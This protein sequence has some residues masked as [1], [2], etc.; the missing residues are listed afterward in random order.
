MGSALRPTSAALDHSAP[1]NARPTEPCSG[2][3]PGP[4]S[5]APHEA[6]WAPIALL[7]FL[8]ARFLPWDRLGFLFC[9]FH[10]LTGFPCL[11]C[12]GTRAFVALA[13]F[14]PATA[15]A[16][17]PLAAAVG[18]AGAA[19]VVHGIGVGLGGWGAWR[20]RLASVLLR[21]VLRGAALVALVGNWAYLI[22]VGR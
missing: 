20:P 16:M 1:T 11:A 12:G 15:F 18:V 14:D 6:I 3:V 7:A 10:L 2:P 13:H 9:P 17:N 19:Y 22:A 4:P 5:G 8:A 21:R